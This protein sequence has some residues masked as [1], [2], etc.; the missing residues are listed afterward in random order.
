MNLDAWNGLKQAG[1][2]TGIA[3]AVGSK[4][5]CDFVILRFL[6]CVGCL[7][8]SSMM[9]MRCWNNWFG[10]NPSLLEISIVTWFIS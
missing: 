6:K 4:L 5:K 3:A 9:F 7:D 8:S 1:T 2:L 10:L